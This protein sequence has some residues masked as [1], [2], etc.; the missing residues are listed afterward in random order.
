MHERTAVEEPAVPAGDRHRAVRAALQRAGRRRERRGGQGLRAGVRAT[1]WC[2]ATRWPSQELA[3]LVRQV[4]RDGQIRETEL[5]MA[6]G[7]AVR[8]AARHG[9][10]RAAGHAGWCSRW[11]RT[12]PASAGSRRSAATSSPT[13]PTSSRPRSARYRLLAEAVAGGRR[14]P[15]GG[16]PLRRPD[17]D[18]ERPADHAGAADH[19]AV[20]APGRR[21]ARGAG[22]SSTWTTWSPR[23]S[24]TSAIDAARPGHRGGHRRRARAAD[25]RQPRRRSRRRSATWSPTRSPTPPTHRRVLV[26]ARAD[27]MNGRDL[28]SP[29]RASASPPAR[30]TGSSSGSTGSTRR[31]TAPPAAPASGCRSSSTSPPRT[32]ARS[33]CGR[34]RARARPSPSPCRAAL[35]PPGRTGHRHDVPIANTPQ[36]ASP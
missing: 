1:G 16:A 34:S 32:A 13:S 14:R 22:R 12:A 8:A 6:R 31:G 21:P 25:L 33:A 17:A 28:P 5:V 24:T 35:R 20:P 30:S 29:T 27:E 10:G 9:A 7:R 15:R 11:S 23:P 3:E 4:R 2:A 36:E 18:R 26:A 19:R